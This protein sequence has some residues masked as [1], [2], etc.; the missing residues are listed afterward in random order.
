M[1]LALHQVAIVTGAA[2]GIGTATAHRLR[3]NGAAVALLDLDEPALL[4]TQEELGGGDDVL[5]LPVDVTDAQAVETAIRTIEARLGPITQAVSAAGILR[6]SAVTRTGDD[7]WHAHLA[8]NATGVFH[9]LRTVGRLM[10]ERR[11]GAIVVV[12]SN[13]SDVPRTAMGPYAASKAAAA[14]LTRTLGLEL[15]GHGVRCNVVEPGSTDS[16]MLRELWSDLDLGA[17]AAIDGDPASYR[18]GIP[19][20]RIAEPEDIA[21]VIAFLLSPA[22]RHMTLQRVRVDGGASL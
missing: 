17:Q 14:A 8:V 2:G 7:A 3:S 10:S 13:A 15:A 18:V 22:A 11:G 19:L 9:L 12:G 6:P 16:P 1:A 5:A 20:G 21:E 4:D